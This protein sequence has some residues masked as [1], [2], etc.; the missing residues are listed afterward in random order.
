MK[1]FYG[2]NPKNFYGK[3]IDRNLVPGLRAEVRHGTMQG[4]HYSYVTLNDDTGV[5]WRIQPSRLSRAGF[6]HAL[7]ATGREHSAVRHE[8]ASPSGFNELVAYIRR[9]EAQERREQGVDLK[10]VWTE[11]KAYKAGMS[12]SE[13]GQGTLP[14][15]F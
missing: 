10:E 6:P 1:R 5:K 11:Y 13:A 15:A 2:F 14:L 7:K 8:Q 12:A 9:Q 4:H 3:W